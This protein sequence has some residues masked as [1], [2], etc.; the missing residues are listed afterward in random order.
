M[1]NE[2]IL[3]DM[4]KVSLL[5]VEDNEDIIKLIDNTFKMLVN[6]ITCAKDGLEAI[7]DFKK[8]K[9]DII[10]TD[11]RMPHCNG[12]E[13]MKAIRE[14]DKEIPIIVI[15]AYVH[16]LEDQSLASY[17]YEKPIDFKKLL[18]KIDELIS[19]D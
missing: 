14:L 8:S 19:K 2:K 1:I 11:I 4:R 18:L 16:E 17:I 12:E 3:S 13:M 10:L 7:E 15:S 5:I 9:P 6:D